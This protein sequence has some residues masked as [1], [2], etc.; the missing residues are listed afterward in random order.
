MNNTDILSIQLY[1]L[2][3]LGKLDRVL[4]VVKEA[5]YVHVETVGSHLDEAESVRGQARRARPQGIIQ[6]R[7]H[8]RRCGS[9]PT[10]LYG[11]VAHWAANSSS[12]RPCRQNNG[13]ATRRSGAR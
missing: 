11:P 2:R 9:G 3:S 10:S 6:P 1:T 12:C 8:G 7:K 13:R 4:D 5:G